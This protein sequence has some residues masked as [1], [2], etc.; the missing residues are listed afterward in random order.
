MYIGVTN[1]ILRRVYEHKHKIIKG[2]TQK[3]N[4]SKLVY[5]ELFEDINLAIMREKELKKWR[6][7][8]KNNLVQN[9]NPEWKDISLDFE[10]KDFSSLS[11]SK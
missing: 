5:Y 4:V 7:E 1:N 10:N 11:S 8:K 6:R 3:Y 9:Q 2:F